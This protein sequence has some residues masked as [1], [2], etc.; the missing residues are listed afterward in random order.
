VAPLVLF[1]LLAWQARAVVDDAY[2]NFRIVENIL[3]G[4]GPVYNVGERVEAGTS[5]AWLAVLS[6]LSALLGPFGLALPWIAVGAGVAAG[7]AG[8]AFAQTT[9]LILCRRAQLAGHRRGA[10]VPAAAWIVI[11]VPP[12]WEFVAS[13]LEV[14]LG[15][16]W[17][18]ASA[19]VV[20]S[21]L[22]S[23]PP[24][25]R[26][27]LIGLGPLVRP[28]FAIL[29][30]VLLP[31]LWWKTARTGAA[32]VRLAAWAGAVPVATE[33]WRMGFYAS[34]VPNTALAKEAF[35]A[36]WSRGFVYLA[37]FVEPYWLVVAVAPVLVMVLR[38][39]RR[40]VPGS[41]RVL[42]AA[43]VIGAGLHGL[44]VVRL[45]GDFMHARML[46]P[47]LF[48][49]LLPAA[50]WP[51]RPAPAA[52]G[53]LK[54]AHAAVLLALPLWAGIS[55]FSLRVPYPG[56]IA[57]HGVADEVNF[58][59]A[60]ARHPHPVMPDDYR[61]WPHGPVWIAD[62]LRRLAAEGRRRLVLDQEQWPLAS[63]PAA[64]IVT[65]GIMIGLVGYVAGPLV[66]LADP[67]GLTDPVAS[68][69]R[70]DDRGRTGHEKRLMRDWLI[71]RFV[72]DG[73]AAE[74]AVKYSQAGAARAALRCGPLREMV[75]AV[76][77]PLTPGRFLRNVM[78]APR[79]TR[80]RVPAQP[81]DAADA[82]CD[83]RQP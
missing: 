83:G 61:G 21:A 23:E 26:A 51:V 60:H 15:L 68:R 12:F 57:D 35:E 78:V 66:H 2:I 22:R 38:F 79:L 50:V 19:Y 9:S 44:Y 37:D 69:L 4:D 46:L 72:A 64:T 58:Y 53:A 1:A 41:E 31:A 63:D 55:A 27:L 32:L 20:A 45:G 33:V 6:G 3:R 70:L 52:S 73:A 28:E 25:W 71:G 8:L 34:L 10:V 54:M 11:G 47:A 30:A 36:V 56:Q 76:T 18:G 29:A 81:L 82:L 7:V 48:A 42:A 67:I 43:L 24:G 80:L 17:I 39:T 5:P 75:E 16:L 13:G 14:G 74:A 40:A 62:E 65:D 59:R 77:G 49:L